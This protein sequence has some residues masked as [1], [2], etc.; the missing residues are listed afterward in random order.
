MPYPFLTVALHE[1]GTRKS[2]FWSVTV[3]KNVSS[4]CNMTAQ[5]DPVRDKLSITYKERGLASPNRQHSFT[6]TSYVC[7]SSGISIEYFL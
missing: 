6:R 5:I 1:S 7:N 4:R 2:I 3:Y